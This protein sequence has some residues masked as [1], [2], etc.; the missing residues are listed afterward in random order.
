M[1]LSVIPNKKPLDRKL[2]ENYS[3]R[4]DDINGPKPKLV[5]HERD[6]IMDT[7]DIEGT[8]SK[9]LVDKSK[10]AKN[11]LY[12]DDIDG[13]KPRIIRQLPH[14]KRMINPGDPVYDLPSYEE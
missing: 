10:P 6:F 12:L 13:A 9:P 14:S 11:L 2:G 3:L 1:N 8:K 7:S 5:A 4:A